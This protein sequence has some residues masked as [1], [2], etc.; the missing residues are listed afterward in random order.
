MR[1]R[2]G[3]GKGKRE[4]EGERTPNKLVISLPRRLYRVN[5]LCNQKEVYQA[6][7]LET[8]IFSVG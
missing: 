8:E 7:G 3:K 5:G 1:E 4:S 2:K 6:S